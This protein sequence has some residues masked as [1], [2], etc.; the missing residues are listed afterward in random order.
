LIREIQIILNVLGL[1]HGPDDGR[2]RP[3]TS[4]ALEGFQHIMWLPFTAVF[5]ATHV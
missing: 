5:N 4:D 1:R 2:M 3:I